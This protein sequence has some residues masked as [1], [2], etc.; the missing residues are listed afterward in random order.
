MYRGRRLASKFRRVD[1]Q[2]LQHLC[3]REDSFNLLYLFNLLNLLNFFKFSHPYSGR[4]SMAFPTSFRIAA[5][6]TCNADDQCND[7]LSAYLAPVHHVM[8]KPM[9][10]AADLIKVGIVASYGEVHNSFTSLHT[11]TKS[12]NSGYST[13]RVTTVDR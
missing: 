9:L 10:R 1:E 5:K 12:I 4:G 3:P 13:A 2:V 11:R 8:S 6:D 7:S